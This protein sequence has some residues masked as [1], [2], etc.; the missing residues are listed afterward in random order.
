[1]NS[2]ILHGPDILI[3]SNGHLQFAF[4]IFAI[5]LFQHVDLQFGRLTIFLDILDN[6]QGEALVPVNF[7]CADHFKNNINKS[8]YFKRRPT[9]KGR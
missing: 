5:Q 1:M 6:L 2:R 4:G 3:T 7:F 9:T 8:L